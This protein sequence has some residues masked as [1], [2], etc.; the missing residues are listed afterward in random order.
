[1]LATRKIAHNTIIQIIGKAANILIGVLAISYLARYLSPSG[2][3]QYTTVL[4]FLQIF[5]IFL[6]F[7]LYL[8][9]LQEIGKDETKKNFILHLLIKKK[10]L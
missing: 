8:V 10:W 9:L 5:G 1:M 4:T 2:F 6:D 3:G 7:G